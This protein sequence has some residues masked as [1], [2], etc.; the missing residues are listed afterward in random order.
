MV[1]NINT[2]V[3]TT[4]S[5]ITH[6]ASPASWYAA[7][8]TAAAIKWPPNNA[9]GCAG[10]KVVKPNKNKVEPPKDARSSGVVALPVT[11]KADVMA[12]ADPNATHAKRRKIALMPLRYKQIR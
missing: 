3:T 11:H 10:G 12:I 4:A 9:R 6:R 7:M 1:S 2:I 8:P 5:A